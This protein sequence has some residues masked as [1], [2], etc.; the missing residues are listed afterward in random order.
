CFG[1]RSDAFRK[2]AEFKVISG[3]R[4]GL[5]GHIAYDGRL[6]NVLGPE[7][8]HHFGVR[9][10]EPARCYSLLAIPLKKKSK[11]EE[12]VVGLLRVENKKSADDQPHPSLSFTEEDEEVIK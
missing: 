10:E 8:V 1:L 5:T 9:G 3:E 12:T 2:G 7:L 4:T 6:F 11:E